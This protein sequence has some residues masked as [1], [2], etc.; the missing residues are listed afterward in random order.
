MD[1]EELKRYIESELQGNLST[2]IDPKRKDSLS[3]DRINVWKNVVADRLCYY[4]LEKE[5]L[6][7]K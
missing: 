4:L 7:T 1:A 3:Q 2:P 6:K 5:Y